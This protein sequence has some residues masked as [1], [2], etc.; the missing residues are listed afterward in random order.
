MHPLR[1]ILAL[2]IVLWHCA[3]GVADN[4]ETHPVLWSIRAITI[5]GGNQAFWLISGMLF[6][7]SSY[8]KLTNDKR[9]ATV[10]LKKRA[11]RIYPTGI[12]SVL[13]SE[14]LSLI[15]HFSESKL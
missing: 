7:L 8:T 9:K 12:V 5:F 11:V 13:I 2:S 6:Y 10:F 1:F 4:Y 14:I 3:F 15:I